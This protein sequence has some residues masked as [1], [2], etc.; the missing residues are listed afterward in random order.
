MRGGLFNRRRL[1]DIF[2][3]PLVLSGSMIF[4]GA[5]VA[6]VSYA[7]GFS[8]GIWKSLNLQICYYTGLGMIL[9]SAAFF[10]VSVLIGCCMVDAKEYSTP[11]TH[12]VQQVD[13][14]TLGKL[15]LIK[16]KLLLSEHE[17]QQIRTSQANV[18]IT[19][20]EDENIDANAASVTSTR[21]PA[22]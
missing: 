1:R 11:E 7:I 2:R 14:E 18:K 9:L 20:L 16:K 6:I 17:H 4:L 13:D 10:V 15:E 3:F 21:V 5:A 22:R 19:E 12:I 8:S